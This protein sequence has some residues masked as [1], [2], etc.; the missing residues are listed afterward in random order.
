MMFP[1]VSSLFAEMVPTWAI[2]FCVS[3]FLL[4]FFQL[5]HHHADGIINPS[6]DLHG[7]VAGGNQFD[8]LTIDGLR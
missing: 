5:V 3:V 2:S 4:H 7:I 6:F 1:M 8:S